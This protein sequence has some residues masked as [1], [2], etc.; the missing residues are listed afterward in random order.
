M[1]H[2]DEPR[3][4]YY[5]ARLTKGG[6]WVGVQVYW[7]VPEINGEPQDRAPR[8]CIRVDGATDEI[9]IDRSTGYRCR[10]AL[11][12]YRYWP[13]IGREE[14]TEAEYRYMVDYARWAKASAPERPE[15]SPRSPV[16]LAEMKAILPPPR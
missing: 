15:A 6:P 12:V 4:G 13:W 11:N 1:T 8:W 3:A 5:R 16:K 9:E 2:G 14:I 7:G 10:V